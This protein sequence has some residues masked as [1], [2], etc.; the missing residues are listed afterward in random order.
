M[1]LHFLD[2]FTWL[3]FVSSF[4]I[5]EYMLNNPHIDWGFYILTKHNF[6]LCQLLD[7]HWILNKLNVQLKLIFHPLSQDTE[8]I[9]RTFLLL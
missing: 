1:N 8:N 6:H 2:I 5:M 4:P 9:L 7:V 3:V